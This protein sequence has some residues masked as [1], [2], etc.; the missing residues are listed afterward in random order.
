MQISLYYE[1]EEKAHIIDGLR[2]SRVIVLPQKR[3]T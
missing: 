3:R 2:N 1:V